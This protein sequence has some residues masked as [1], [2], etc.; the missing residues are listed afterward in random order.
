M[1]RVL[2]GDSIEY[3]Q[4]R[5]IGAITVFLIRIQDYKKPETVNL[6]VLSRQHTYNLVILLV[7]FADIV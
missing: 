3:I 1:M 5:R 6:P 2:L 4:Q 7:I